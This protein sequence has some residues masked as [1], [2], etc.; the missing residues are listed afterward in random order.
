MGNATGEEHKPLPFARLPIQVNRRVIGRHS[1]FMPMLSPQR[2]AQR[3]MHNR[4]VA[5]CVRQILQ[6]RNRPIR[7]T[8]GA[9]RIGAS[10]HRRVIGRMVLGHRLIGL[11]RQLILLQIFQ[12]LRRQKDR[13]HMAGAQIIGNP[14][15][16]QRVIRIGLALQRPCDGVKHFGHPIERRIDIGKGQPVTGHQRRAHGRQPRI[17]PRVETVIQQLERLFIAVQLAQHFGTRHDAPPGHQRGTA[18]FG[19]HQRLGA[20]KI[21]DRGQR[22]RLVII[23]KSGQPLFRR[24]LVKADQRAGHVALAQKSP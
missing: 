14:R 19:G 10:Q 21:P 1:L 6:N 9:Q 8:A 7:I 2:I 18:T 15:I 13:I 4:Q 24:D 20:L 12:Q 3:H 22:Q 5:M 11:L 16:E 23:G 17:E